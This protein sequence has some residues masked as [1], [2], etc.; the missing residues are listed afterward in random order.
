MKNIYQ[1][2]T[3]LFFI[4]SFNGFSQVD[5]DGDGINDDVDNCPTVA[6]GY[7]TE[8]TTVAGGNEFGSAAN[9]LYWPRDIII[10]AS[11]NYYI[12]DA[13]NNRIQ[14]WEP[15]AT[16]GTTIAG[17]NVD[18]GDASNQLYRPY[19]I[20]L[21][22]SGNLYIADTENHRIQKWEPGASEGTTVAGGNS[23]GSAANQLKYPYRFTF[24]SS[25]N[26]YIADTYNHRIQ[27]WAP[28]ASEG[29][30]V[31]GGNSY[32]S[33]ANQLHYPNGI[34]FDASGN[35]YIS[36]GHNNRIQK[37]TPGAIEGTTVAGGNG[38][39]SNSNQLN[40]PY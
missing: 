17:G 9:Q 8:G 36:D 34:T 26:L 25:G 39:G 16:E 7:S 4:I 10:D 32:G 3:L 27:K 24:D 1:S 5:T 11:G 23:Y 19:G 30:T 13:Q 6:N 2:L 18:W 28:G 20:A 21:D 15:G 12:A 37:W 38:M 29:T 22:A 31:A 35:L 33:A 14:K 40:S